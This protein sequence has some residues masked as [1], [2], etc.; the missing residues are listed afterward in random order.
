MAFKGRRRELKL[1]QNAWSGPRSAFIPIYGRRRVGKSELI[2]HFMT[3]KPGL[4]FV[5]KRAPGTAQIGEFLEVAARALSEP[6][7]AQIRPSGWKAAFEAVIE[8]ANKR[9]TKGKFILALDEFQWI[10]AADPEIASV[11]QEL[12]DRQWSQSAKVMLI[13]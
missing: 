3:D 8:R 2:V 10:A 1:L 9:A 13:L 7:L 11:L 12:W 5:G 4:Y 6:L